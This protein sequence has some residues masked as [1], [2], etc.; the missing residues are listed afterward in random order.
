MSRM[1]LMPLDT[2]VTGFRPI[3]IKSAEMSIVD[4]PLRCTPPMPPV[5]KILMPQRSAQMTVDA[6]VVPPF[7]C[8]PSTYGK[9]RREVFMTSDVPS[10]SAVSS[11][12]DN[13]IL[14]RPLT[15]AIVAGTA[16]CRN[17]HKFN[18]EALARRRRMAMVLIK[19]VPEEI[20]LCYVQETCRD[21]SFRRSFLRTLTW[22]GKFRNWN[23]WLR[24]WRRDC[25]GKAVNLWR[26]EMSMTDAIC[27]GFKDFSIAWS[28]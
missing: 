6:T 27:S 3:S 12:L 2:T 18:E 5:A 8:F 16:P 7:N 25:K 4:S 1:D 11:P 15:M 22:M 21:E 9:S 23:K 13:P 19:T 20:K 28:L 24:Q 26:T 10:A 14:I 17:L